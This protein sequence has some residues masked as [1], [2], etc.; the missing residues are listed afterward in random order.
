[1][2]NHYKLLF[3]KLIEFNCINSEIILNVINNVA[4]CLK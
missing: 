3:K 2:I 4:K 1:M